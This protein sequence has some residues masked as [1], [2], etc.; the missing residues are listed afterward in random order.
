MTSEALGGRDGSPALLAGPVRWIAGSPL[1]AFLAIFLVGLVLRL[2]M[3]SF[4]PKDLIPP[5]PKWETGAVAISLA[6]TGRFADPY[7][8][9]TGP[10]A[11]M[12]PLQVGA[13][14]LLYR[15]LGVGHAGGLVRWILVL[16]VCSLLWASLPWL[17]NRLGVG[18]EAGVVGGMAG[19]LAVGFPSEVEPVSALA[20]FALL[21]LFAARWRRSATSLGRSLL[22]G[23]A[24]GVAFHLQPV[25][26]P[27]V[28]GC[29]AFE[30]WWSREPRKVGFAGMLLLGMLLAC[31]PWGWRNYQTFEK[32]FFIRGNLGLEL[33]VG[34]HPG[35]HADIDV[36]SARRSFRHPRTDLAEAERVLEIGEAAYMREKQHEALAWIGDN[37]GEFLRLT[38]TRVLY[39]WLGPL[40]EPVRAFGYTVLFLLA[41]V[42]AWRVLPNLRA[43]E[44]AALLI[45]LATY[46]LV[47]YVVA[48]M[49][50]YGEPV[51]WI[52]F[53][54]AGGAVWGW[55]GEGS[56]VPRVSSR[57]EEAPSR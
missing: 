57:R 34:N 43:P 54:F 5:N 9:P 32:V 25:L 12:Q 4:V 33:Y 20:L 14:S 47:Y 13:A 53:L 48:Y 39:F 42:G 50:R 28:L 16:A 11:H 6:Q 44:R 24:T 8:I 19:A 2:W 7:L 26:L 52:L 10:T 37:P 3:F 41:V 1:R 29:V 36:S 46:P 51:R 49:P 35:A 31:L 15:V 17:G 55:V 18:R 45:P 21:A 23:L 30:L 27:V 22:L 38:A 56:Q 40:H